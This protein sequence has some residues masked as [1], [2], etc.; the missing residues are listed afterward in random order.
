[1][2]KKDGTE[3]RVDNPAKLPGEGEIETLMEP[4][5]WRTSSCPNDL[6]RSVL[7]LCQDRRGL[8]ER[9]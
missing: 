6:R 7:Q 5:C 2:I 9:H 3:L 8:Q 4:C 1:V